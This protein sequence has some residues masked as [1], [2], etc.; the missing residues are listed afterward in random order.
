MKHRFII[1]AA[2]ALCAAL[3]YTGAAQERL[4]PQWMRKLPSP[5]NPSFEYVTV[6]A[7][8]NSLQQARKD[9]LTLVFDNTG[10]ANGVLVKVDEQSRLAV[11]K[12]WTDGK[13][14][15]S[16]TETFIRNSEIKSGEFKVYVKEVAEHYEVRDGIFEMTKLYQ[17]SVSDK[18]PSFD[19]VTVTDRY[20]FA[21]VLLSIIPGCGQ[22]KKGDILKGSLFMG[23]VAAAA[24]GTAVLLNLGNEMT[25]KM[26][27]SHNADD[28]MFY[29]NTANTYRTC[30]YVC[31]GLGAAIYVY[32]LIDAAAAPGAKRLIVTPGTIGLSF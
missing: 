9:C 10:Y 11:D 31:I 15:D 8:A 25:T 1:A 30:A 26:N 4:R 27:I 18:T 14:I 6:K 21:P 3:P 23:G 19:A 28:I 32:N 17:K 13:L 29:S 5:S 12:N 24:T 20:G 2:L 7:A 22:F 16:Q